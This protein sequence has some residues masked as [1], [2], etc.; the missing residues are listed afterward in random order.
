MFKLEDVELTFTDAALNAA[1]E[2]AL[3]RK[4]GARGLR[5]IIEESLLDVMYEL[6]SLEHVE[7]CVIDATSEGKINSPVLLSKTGQIIEITDM[8][9]NH[10]KSA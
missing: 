10:S 7:K 4:T 3:G 1:A 6:P 8:K 9:K 2:L 5:A